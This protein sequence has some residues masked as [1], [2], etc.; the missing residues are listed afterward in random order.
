MPIAQ[1]PKR[2]TIRTDR[3]GVERVS[4]TV[5]LP[6]KCEEVAKKRLG[7]VTRPD[8]TSCYSLKAVC[9]AI[10]EKALS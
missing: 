1:I 5:Y 2:K 4:I 9:E 7:K 6:L 10:L 3:H 8:G